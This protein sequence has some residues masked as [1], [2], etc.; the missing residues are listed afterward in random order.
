MLL[1]QPGVAF[2]D[3][4]VSTQAVPGSLLR[5]LFVLGVS[6]EPRGDAAAQRLLG[7]L[8]RGRGRGRRRRRGRLGEV[9]MAGLVN[10]GRQLLIVLRSVVEMGTQ[11]MGARGARRRVWLLLGRLLGLLRLLIWAWRYAALWNLLLVL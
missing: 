10:R 1:C 2:P 6:R 11:A 9:T 5:R 3:R 8:R 4:L 7:L